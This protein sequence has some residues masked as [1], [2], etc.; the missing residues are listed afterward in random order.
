MRPAAECHRPMNRLEPAGRRRSRRTPAT[1][2]TGTSLEPL[3][4]ERAARALFRRYLSARHN[5]NHR[6][7][8][9]NNQM[10]EA[11]DVEGSGLSAEMLLAM[12]EQANTHVPAFK[13]VP[14]SQMEWRK[15]EAA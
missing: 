6:A 8:F 11:F 7:K 13:F 14:C 9:V 15:I 10:G 5:P 1:R 3:Q 4:R 12:T 2:G